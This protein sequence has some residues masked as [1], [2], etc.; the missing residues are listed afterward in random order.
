MASLTDVYDGG[1]GVV[2]DPGRRLAGAA[3]FL[4]GA[5]M[6]VGAIP[7]ATTDLV[8]ALGLSVYEA[9]ELAGVLAGLGVPAVFV[10][11]LTVVP[12]GRRIRVG[13]TVGASLALLGVALFAYAYPYSW[14]SNDPMLTVATTVLYSAGTLV[15][16]WCVFVGIA[17]F[18]TRSDPGGSARVEITDEGVVEIVSTGRSVPGVGGIG[19]FGTDPDGRVE[20]QT[21][22]GSDGAA[23][24]GTSGG[25]D[26]PARAGD[27]AGA[28][29][30]TEPLTE[31]GPATAD[32]DIE[33]AVSERGRPDR[34][35]GNCLH[36][37]YVRVDGEITP[38]CGRH[39]ELLEDMDACD[40]W[41][42]NS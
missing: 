2:A 5:A 23:V 28:V 27:G 4:A 29:G 36:F 38:Y 11:I 24:T 40:Q 7:L 22:R 30:T 10:G 13:G 31:T 42:A 18:K 20:T 35:C 21:N 41:D 12:A 34:Y 14:V 15:T 19:L 37:E 39:T 33:Q 6:V 1:V 8:R 25:S 16:F 3:L 9:R 26:S 17:T 32:A